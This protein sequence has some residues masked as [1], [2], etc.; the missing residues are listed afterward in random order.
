MP[1][2]S[3][4]APARA[5]HACD[6][7]SDEEGWTVV[8]SLETARQADSAPYQAGAKGDW[9]VDRSTTVIPF[10]NYFNPIGIYS[11][12]SYTLAPITAEERVSI[13][14]ATPGGGSEPVA[15]YAGPCPPK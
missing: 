3:L 10:C 6:P 4:P 13:C 11:M 12:R 9:Y 15:P 2:V 14:R 1:L 8:P 5:D 7:V